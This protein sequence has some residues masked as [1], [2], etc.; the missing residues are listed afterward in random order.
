MNENNNKAISDGMAL[1]F[2]K[3]SEL[4]RKNEENLKKEVEGIKRKVETNQRKKSYAEG[5]KEKELYD[6]VVELESV[7]FIFIVDHRKSH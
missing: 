7:Y 4:E 3:M 2:A 1:I 6:R 5:D